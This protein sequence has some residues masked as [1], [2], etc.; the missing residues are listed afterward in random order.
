[1]KKRT[2]TETDSLLRVPKAKKLGLKIRPIAMPH[3]DLIKAE[4]PAPNVAP[5]SEES[6]REA[7]AVLPDDLSAAAPP[8]AKNP[9]IAPEKDFARVPN[10]IKRAVEAGKFPNSSLAIYLYL[11]SV[12]RG[13]VQP[14]R[15]VRMNKSKLL[16]GASL[17]T[18]KALVKNLAHLKSVGLVKI[19]VFN[20]DH[21]G[22]EYEVLIPEEIEGF[23]PTYLPTYLLS[24]G[25][26]VPTVLR[27]VGRVVKTIDNKELK[28]AL[29]LSF[30]DI[31]EN[32]DDA[33]AKRAANALA[34][35]AADPL[36]KLAA[37]LDES[38]RKLTNK[39]LSKKDADAWNELA[40]LLAAEL[41]IAAARAN[42]ISSVPAFLTEH[43]HRRLSG[44]T[45]T[46]KTKVS[47]SLQVDRT[48]PAEAE[49]FVAEP[50]TAES[51][52]VVLKTFRE[53]VEKGQRDFVMSFEE[54]YTG[55]DW[56]FLMENLKR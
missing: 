35:L 32:D 22:N 31:E 33:S 37:T 28:D 40:K 14:Q 6:E 9:T 1:M 47:K 3:D 55:E 20:G 21:S 8:A 30:K 2:K 7:P 10:S 38:S 50:L 27:T 48:Q 25:Q 13:A 11:F 24:S 53:Y 43:L 52:E 19:T 49:P 36:A 16:L 46:P 56:L 54:T 45:E 44:K 41:E 26:W 51:R 12:T 23:L 15:S 4:A 17:R 42:S 29:R 34:K 5:P 39:S 18:E